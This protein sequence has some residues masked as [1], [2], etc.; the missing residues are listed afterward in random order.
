MLC[1][2]MI[3][4]VT[5][6]FD[7]TADRLGVK[8]GSIAAFCPLLA[9]AGAFSAAPVLWFQVGYGVLL[10]LS[11]G[12]LLCRDGAACAIAMLFAACTGACGFALER[13]ITGFYEPGLLIALP[14]AVIAAC[15]LADRRAALLSVVAAPM[16]YAVCVMLEGYYLFQTVLLDF[17]AQELLDAQTCGAV[18]LFFFWRLRWRNRKRWTNTAAT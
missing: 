9:A 3:L 13:T 8:T 15:L 7:G 17:A 11:C 6:L 1:C 14:T 5:G 18:L 16:F 10:F 12:V 2:V 4:C